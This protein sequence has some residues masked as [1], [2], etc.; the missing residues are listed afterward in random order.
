[1]DLSTMIVSSSFVDTVWIRSS[2]LW[3]RSPLLNPWICFFQT[4]NNS[5]SVTLTQ[6]WIYSL[7]I[8]R[9]KKTWM[10]YTNPCVSLLSKQAWNFFDELSSNSFLIWVTKSIECLTSGIAPSFS[11]SEGAIRLKFLS[12]TE[13]PSGSMIFFCSMSYTKPAFWTIWKTYWM[14]LTK[15]SVLS[16][17]LRRTTS[18][19]AYLTW[20]I[21][22]FSMLWLSTF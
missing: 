16:I 1:M 8:S 12:V 19:C 11:K 5:L 9:L 17:F 20:K 2:K 21:T 22:F 13:S 15:S 6:A 10:H 3:V 7:R 4:L 14:S 18:V